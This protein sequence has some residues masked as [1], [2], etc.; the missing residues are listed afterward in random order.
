MQNQQVPQPPQPLDPRIIP[1]Y[2]RDDEISLV[3]LWIAIARRKKLVLTVFILVVTLGLI[4]A[5]AIPKSYTYSTAIEISKYWGGSSYAQLESPESVKSKLENVY[6]PQ[7]THSE[8]VSPPLEVRVENPKNSL[9]LILKSKTPE[10]DAERTRAVHE[11]IVQAIAKEHAEQLS[12]L[13]G[14]YESQLKAAQAEAHALESTPS[15]GT[16]TL[17][18]DKKRQ[19]N[20]LT[21]RI[22]GMR[23]TYAPQLATRSAKPSSPSKALILALAGFLGLF[24]GLFA[25][26][27]AEFRDKVLERMAEQGEESASA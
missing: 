10:A 3:D 24:A 22:D 13:R 12:T 14:I 20:D 23:P 18:L 1:A 9:V 27:I 7:A 25:A 5:F 4:V 6:I 2:Y 21:S 11:R 26:F 17:L 15:E 8:S 16:L 19:I